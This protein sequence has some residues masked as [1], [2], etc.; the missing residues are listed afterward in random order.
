MFN[1]EYRIIFFLIT[2]LVYIFE[3]Y[4]FLLNIIYIFFFLILFFIIL[5]IIY[6]V[7]YD[8]YINKNYKYLHRLWIKNI[9]K[10]NFVYKKNKNKLF[11]LCFNNI[12]IP[13]VNF[14]DLILFNNNKKLIYT[15]LKDINLSVYSIY[16]IFYIWE[17]G[18]LSNKIALS[19]IKASSRGVDCKIILDSIG[20]LNF[21]KTI[22]PLIMRKHGIKII[23]YSKFYF[24][25][26]LFKRI[27]FR[28][29]KKIILIDHYITYIGSMNLVDCKEFKK[30]L[31][32]GK[33]IDLMVRIKGYLVNKIIKLIFFYEWEIET[34]EIITD[35]KIVY[36][37]IKNDSNKLIQIVNYSPGLPNDLIHRVL[38]N[39]I[40]STKKR[41]IITTPY[42]VPDNLLIDAIC[43]IANKGIDVKI[44]L[45]QKSDSFL[46]YWANRY[47]L[48]D[49]YLS[50]IKIY[51]YKN[52]FLHSKSILVDDNISILGSINFD[53]RSIWLNFEI[54]L[55][56]YNNNINKKLYKI[57]KQ[58]ILQSKLINYNFFKK[59]KLYEKFFEKISYLF[60]SFL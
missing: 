21:F 34:G 15:L 13:P 57:H 55:V 40:Y 46:V 41:L 1:I 33:C 45:S 11:N 10:L 44:I 47:F 5:L 7:F 16:I 3:K 24:F 58:Y 30:Y 31:D 51:F 25:E 37:N 54:A 43:F 18:F 27:D 35:T 17:P 59:K 50:N 28:Q 6:N 12:Y 60:S 52:N 32:L 38:L 56:I 2:I 29:H 49:L 20:S 23:E 42:L 26:I 48:K 4:Y 19:L 36:K 8:F 22:W 14:N 39:I 9:F 53:I